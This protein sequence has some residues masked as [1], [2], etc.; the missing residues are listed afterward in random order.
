VSTIGPYFGD[1]KNNDS[2]IMKNIIYNNRDDFRNW[3]RS[4]DILVIDRGFRDSLPL[5]DS[6]G[7]KTYMPKF[8]NKKQNQFTTSEANETRLTTKVRW[9]VEST[10][11]RVKQ[12]KIFDKVMYN[13]LIPLIGDYFSIVCAMI[14]RFCSTFVYD[15]SKDEEIAEKMLQLVE[16]SNEL[17]QYIDNLKQ[18]SDKNIK[19]HNLDAAQALN[20]FPIFS[21]E[22]LM[23]LTLG[24]YQLKQSKSYAIEHLDPNGEY[25]V[26]ISNQEKY[27]LRARIQSRHSQ[28]EKYNLWIKY[29]ANDINGWYCTCMVGARVV[30][31][32]SHISSVIWYLSYA[33]FDPRELRQQSSDYLDEF[34][35]APDY[36]IDNSDEDSNDSDILYSLP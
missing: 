28:S 9:I 31:C 21:Y 4:G 8:L 5:L 20:D 27:L 13:T 33:R 7:Y 14:N 19:W 18:S 16:H 10:N 6:L 32:C 1:A 35:D 29:S 26:K 22:S 30:G 36:E 11:G 3:L 17:K 15:T 34:L 12:W 24:I 2:E 25:H 23:D